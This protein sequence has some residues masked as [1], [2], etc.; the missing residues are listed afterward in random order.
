[1]ILKIFI[2][3]FGVKIVIRLS[4]NHCDLILTIRFDLSQNSLYLPIFIDILPIF[5]DICSIF[6]DI[7]SIFFQKFQHIC[8]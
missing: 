6:I 2:E 3:F 4:K 7:L 1:M 8:V 5:I